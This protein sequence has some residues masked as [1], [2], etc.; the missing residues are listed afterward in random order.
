[1]KR[2]SLKIP[3]LEYARL[4]QRGEHRTKTPEVL[5]LILTEGNMSF[6]YFLFH[7]GKSMM[8]KE[9]PVVFYF[10]AFL[11]KVQ[12]GNWWTNKSKVE[13]PAVNTCQAASVRKPSK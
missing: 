8:L 4:A 7:I 2:D 6:C 3:W 5:S 1:M 11:I 12:K 9:L 13:Y 10:D